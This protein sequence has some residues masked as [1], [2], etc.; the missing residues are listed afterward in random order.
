MTIRAVPRRTPKAAELDADIE[1]ERLMAA[2]SNALYAFA[3][4]LTD[5]HDASADCVQHAF[6]AAYDRLRRGKSVSRAWLYRVTRNAGIDCLRHKRKTAPHDSKFASAES[7]PTDT[8]SETVRMRASLEA[9]APEDREVLFLFAV[10][11]LRA[12]EIGQILGIR[13][14]AVWMRVSRARKRLRIL[15]GE[16]E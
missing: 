15:L 9:M 2:Y 13:R 16:Q 11:K 5:D 12:D 6:I 4:Q 14:E 10:D 1:L 8:S 3:V 7:A